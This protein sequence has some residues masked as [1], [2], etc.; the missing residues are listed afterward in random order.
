MVLD[1]RRTRRITE[2]REHT[3]T[4]TRQTDFAHRYF[5]SIRRRRRKNLFC[6]IELE[7]KKKDS[8]VFLL[9]IQLIRSIGFN[10]VRQYHHQHTRQNL[11]SISSMVHVQY[12]EYLSEEFPFV[13]V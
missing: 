11:Y 9:Y 7:R 1:K 4:H 2:E 12:D 5:T 6:L 10:Q 8:C 13:T 3:R